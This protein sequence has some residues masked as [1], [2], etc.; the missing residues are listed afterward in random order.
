MMIEKDKKVAEKILGVY[1][2]RRETALDRLKQTHAKARK[3][4]TVFS[5]VFGSISA[6]IMGA[7]MSLLMTDFAGLG[8]VNSMFIGVVLGVIGMLGAALT[9]PI[10]KRKIAKGK[11]KYASEIMQCKKELFGE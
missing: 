4:A 5:Y 8:E 3:P 7:G 2:E 1:E 11:K 10:Y 9:Y 6:L